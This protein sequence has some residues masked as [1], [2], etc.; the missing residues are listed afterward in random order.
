M[1]E[2]CTKNIPLNV[3]NMHSAGVMNVGSNE[4]LNVL[5]IVFLN[6]KTIRFEKEERN[7]IVIST[8]TEFVF[9]N[10]WISL[11]NYKCV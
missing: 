8:H 2:K 7:V 5:K 11:R 10:R 3:R 4:L 6:M 9:I 1:F